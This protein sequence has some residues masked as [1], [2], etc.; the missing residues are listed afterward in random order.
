M[1]RIESVIATTHVDSQGDQ[2]SVEALRSLVESMSTSL[3]PIGSEHDPRRPPLGRIVSGT[4]RQREDGEYEAVAILEMFENRDEGIVADE[5]RE[6]VLPKYRAK[7]LHISHDWAH[8]FPEDQADIAEISKIFGNAP[9]YEVKKAADPIS[10]I[11]IAGAFVLGGIASGFLKEI[12]SDGWK[13]VKPR[14]AALFS[15]PKKDKGERLLSFCVLMDV[16]GISV[17]IEIIHTN[18]SPDEVSDFLEKGLAIVE[19]VLPYYLQNAP[20]I[21]RLVFEARG[22]EINVK[23]AVR[24]DCRPLKPSLSVQDVIERSRGD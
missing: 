14:L 2:L 20:D 24:K 12:G 6:V 13:L 23:F 16:N 3:I 19:S 5:N 17:E 15:R 8:R 11:T 10:V 4:V 1:K 7:G 9:V 21:R 22:S 18:P